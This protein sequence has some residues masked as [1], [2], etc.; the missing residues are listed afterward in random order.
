MGRRIDDIKGI[1]PTFCMHQILL[2]DEYKSK[3]QPQR[4]LNL[5]MYEVVKKVVIKLLDAGMLYHIS[6]SVWYDCDRG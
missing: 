3:A 1:S 2:Q 6:D 4:R 5:V